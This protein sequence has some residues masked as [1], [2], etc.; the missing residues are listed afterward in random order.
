MMKIR[1]KE[2]CR[3]GTRTNF[4]DEILGKVR[5]QERRNLTDDVNAGAEKRRLAIELD[6]NK[7]F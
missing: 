1:E 5:E 2:A 4:D 3:K 7:L 6:W